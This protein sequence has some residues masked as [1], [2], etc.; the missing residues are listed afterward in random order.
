VNTATEGTAIARPRATHADFRRL[1]WGVLAYNVLVVLW[2]A[3]V[4]ATGSGAGCGGHWPLCNGEI[5]PSA[6]GTATIVEYTHRAMS[7]LALAAVFG[8]W[9][10]SCRLFPKRHRVRRWAALSFGFLV[11]EAL[12]GAGL[13]VFDYVAQNASLGRAFYLAA[14][15]ANT[16]LLLAALV[17]TAW[18]AARGEA[19]LD[20]SNASKSLLAALPLVVALS[21]TG[22]VA[23]LGD[24][25]FPAPSLRAG[26][27]QEFSSAAQFLLRLRILHPLFAVLV[28]FY[29]LYAASSA[30]RAR[31]SK[32]VRRGAAAV[33]ALAVAQLA[34]GAV[35]VALLA[36]VWMQLLH[37][38]LADL[39][40]ISLVLL[41]ANVAVPASSE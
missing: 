19:P 15:L 27:A 2:G 4:R 7:G 21:M 25:L 3:L 39:V 26:L 17:M 10:W 40:W 12:L 34:A 37:L 31:P 35:N 1:A 24:T 28:G 16:Q 22:A 14:H 18:L 23:A 9:L 13:V 11:L 38:L 29:L 5:V 8:L 30:A 41:T 33:A 36:P 20:F 32:A 6:G